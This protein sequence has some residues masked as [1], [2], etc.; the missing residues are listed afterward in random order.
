MSKKLLRQDLVERAQQVLEACPLIPVI[1]IQQPEHAL[2]LAQALIDGGLRVLE[3]TLRTPHGLEAIRQIRET[4]PDIWVGAGTVLAPNQFDQALDHGAQFVIS[5]GITRKLLKHGLDAEVPLLPGIATV[6]ELMEGVALGYR[7]FK[8]FPAE[9][10]GGIAAL[11]SFAG[12]LPDV[13]FCPT[14]GIRQETAKNYLALANVCAVG[15]TWLTPADV[16]STSDWAQ[17]TEISKSSLTAL[18]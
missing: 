4:F 11:K 16:V 10:A 12:P 3:V 6:S 5:P 17:I 1:S 2:P 14:G 7:Y 18:T 15:G 8:F 13:R 9:V